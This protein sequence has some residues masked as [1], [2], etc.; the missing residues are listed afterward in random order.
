MN[1][2]E[3]SLYIIKHPDLFTSGDI[4]YAQLIRNQEYGYEHR[5]ALD[6]STKGHQPNV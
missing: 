4:Q 1:T 3:A 6:E 2:D 5:Q